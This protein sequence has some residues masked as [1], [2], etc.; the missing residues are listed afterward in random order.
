MA[1][2]HILRLS[3]LILIALIIGCNGTD[4][5]VII[6]E[7]PSWSPDGST[8]AYAKPDGIW[9]VDAD[10]TNERYF[11]EGMQVD[12]SPDG[13]RLV[14]ATL[15]W[16]I[17]LI[18]KDGSNL[19]WLIQDGQSNSPAWSPDGKWVAF[20]RPFAPGGLFWVNIETDEYGGMPHVGGGDWSPN[21]EQIVY[22]LFE[23]QAR[24][25]TLTLVNI[26]DSTTFQV[27]EFDSHEDGALIPPPRWSPDGDKILFVMDLD[28]WVIDTSGQNLKRLARDAL[29]P[30]WSPD[31]ESIIY[32]K[33]KD[34]EYQ[35]WIMNANGRN[36][37]P[38]GEE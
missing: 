20:V 27:K 30:A 12:W 35:L 25:Q 13:Q 22:I 32:T 14:I 21:S 18:D 2:K 26:K 37:H 11:A 23:D 28:T 38:L 1:S 10:G 34:D 33:V 16:C 19:E 29:D 31:G 7:R 8:I 36:E 17:Y 15:G 4:E 6:G 9:L 3:F 5:P 24:K